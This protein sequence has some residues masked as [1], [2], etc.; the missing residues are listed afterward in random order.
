MIRRWS[1]AIQFIY[2]YSCSLLLRCM[3]T[4]QYLLT[5]EN[6]NN[7]LEEELSFY[8]SYDYTQMNDQPDY[9]DDYYA[10]TLL[11]EKEEY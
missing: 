4:D 9:D 1:H 5:A 2:F 10:A 8:L 11:T 3:Y 6:Y 7:Y